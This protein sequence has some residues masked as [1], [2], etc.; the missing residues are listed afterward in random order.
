MKLKIYDYLHD[1]EDM[2]LPNKNGKIL[3]DNN[4]VKRE[5]TLCGSN[6]EVVKYLVDNKYKIYVKKFEDYFGQCSNRYLSELI[7][8]KIYK[9]N[10]INVATAFPCKKRPFDDYVYVATED[11]RSLEGIEVDD[12]NEFLMEDLQRVGANNPHLMSKYLPQEWEFVTNPKMK[13][14]LLTKMTPEAYEELV[15]LMII[16]TLFYNFDR[17]G[18]VKNLFFAKTPNSDKIEGLVAIDQEMFYLYNLEGY[19]NVSASKFVKD[20]YG[21]FYPAKAVHGADVFKSYKDRILAIKYLA[22]NGYFSKRQI[23]LVYDVLSCNISE[24]IEKIIDKYHL[25]GQERFK[26]IYKELWNRNIDTL[27][28]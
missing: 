7:A 16:D 13:E 20:M 24:E 21:D 9:D 15:D 27:S 28:L 18:S 8:S 17:F 1:F 11:L 23:K 5:K 19:I 14:F 4:R 2:N 10:D 6:N 22:N 25:A 26:E 12:D 3:L